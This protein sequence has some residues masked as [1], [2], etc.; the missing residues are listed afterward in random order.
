MDATSLSSLLA[1]LATRFKV[2]GATVAVLADGVVTE[3]AHGV[4]SLET[5]VEATTDSVFQIGSISKVYTATVVMRLVE[6]GQL[7]LDEPVVSVLP[8]FAVADPDVSKEVTVRHL[9]THTSG[10]DGDHFF[11]T[12]R[13]DDCL[14]RYVQSLADLGQSHPLGATM[15][16]CNAGYSALGRVIEVVTG[17]QWDAAMRELLF[18]PAGFARTMT[19]PEDVIRY[20]AAVGHL[21]KPGED[22]APTPVWGLMRSCGPA[23]L[24]CATASDVIGFARM[25]LD[26]GAPVLSAASTAAMRVPQVAV[27]DRWTLGDHWGLG[28]ILFSWDGRPVFGHDGSTIGQNAYLRVVPDAGIAIALLTNGG[29]GGDLYQHLYRSLLADL[30]GLD[31]PARPAPPDPPV[32]ADLDA[33]TGVYERSAARIEMTVE[34]GALT[35]TVTSTGP[36]AAIMPTTVQ[37][38][39]LIPVDPAEHLFVTRPEGADTWVPVVF[40]TLPDGSRYVHFGARATPLV[41]GA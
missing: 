30:A 8:E 29:S 21:A 12:G 17:T 3:A 15:S 28:W 9:L 23:G 7:S 6:E 27:P 32:T 13:G 40:F 35:A 11:D 10:I 20:R 38:L 5:Q 18:E 37:T 2:P 16:Y 41:S 14:E 39:T 31:M 24:I 4:L 22:P 19:L 33:H 34:D 1:D 25:H 36:L 26:G